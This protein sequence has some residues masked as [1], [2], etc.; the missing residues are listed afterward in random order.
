[1][2]ATLRPHQEH[3]FA[4]LLIGR[5]ADEADLS[6]SV[7]YHFFVD[8]D[9]LMLSPLDPLLAHFGSPTSTHD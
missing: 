2:E 3:G 7:V 9:D 5:I 6:N 8:N 4:G 1:M